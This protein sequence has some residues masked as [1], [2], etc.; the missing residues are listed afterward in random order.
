[1][2][3]PHPN[4]ARVRAGIQ[5]FIDGD[6]SVLDELI[7]DD[8]VWH[9]PGTHAIAG[10]YHGKGELLPLFV[11][12][13]EE[14]GGSV[15]TDLKDVW[16]DDTHAVVF[17]HTTAERLGRRQDSLVVQIFRLTPDGRLAERWALSND[18]AEIDAFWA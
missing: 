16:A 11:R 8:V 1:V 6:L 15:R 5:A 7:A 18:Q 3:A 4:I 14:T 9:Q 2:A 13:H 12:I 10:D 17:T